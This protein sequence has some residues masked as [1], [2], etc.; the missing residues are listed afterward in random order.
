MVNYWL[1]VTNEENWDIIRRKR[2]W[3]IPARY[4]WLISKV[5]KG[6]FFVFYVSPKKITGIFQAVSEPF[7]DYRRLFSYKGFKRKEI[8][9]HRVK[10]KPLVIAKE[11]IQ[12]DNLVRKL[13]FIINKDK[14]MGYIRRAMIPIPKEDYDL[15]FDVVLTKSKNA[16]K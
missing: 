8:F 16:S 12:F 2:I 5:Q 10:V 9:P 15:I 3:G 1:C 11:P 7:K 14:W 13:K 6:D 4:K